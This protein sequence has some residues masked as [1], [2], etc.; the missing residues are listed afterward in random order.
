MNH[1]IIGFGISGMILFLELM[2]SNTDYNSI[3]LIDPNWLGGD[4]VLKYGSVMSNTPWSKTR[5]VLSNYEFAEHAIKKGDS[6]Y[7]PDELMLVSDMAKYLLAVCEPFFKKIMRITCFVRQICETENGWLIKTDSECVIS[8]NVYLC[9]GAEPKSFDLS[10]ATIPLEIGLDI[11]RLKK[12]VQPKTSVTVIGCSHS[13]LIIIRNLHE[14]G[15]NVTGI[16]KGNEPIQYARNGAHNGVKGNI[17]QFAD[18]VRDGKYENIKLKSWND[19]SSSFKSLLQS[20][21]IL[22]ATGFKKRTIHIQLLDGSHI[23]SEEYDSK[24]GVVRG[25]KG[26]YG[27]GIAYPGIIQNGNIHYEDIG[28]IPFQE[29]IW[30]IF[31]EQTNII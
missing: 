22:V 31:K 4:L 14:I 15:A 10:I 17:V 25:K 7:K 21:S 23:D 8:K 20:E 9:L 16:Y 19:S 27:L 30:R 1:S 12:F 26:L 29:Q 24:T 11:E 6:I 18:D 3:C 2:K 13:G 28:L 5:K